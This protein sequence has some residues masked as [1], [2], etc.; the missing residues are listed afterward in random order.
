MNE[1]GL[2]PTYEQ[3]I[4]FY[5]K[6]DV[7]DVLWELSNTR[8]LRFFYHTDMDFTTRGAKAASIRLH[9]LASRQEFCDAIRAAARRFDGC[10]SPFFPFFGMQTC[11]NRRGRPDDV[12]GWDV[13]FE[14]DMSLAASFRGL[15]P[16][17]AVLEHFG[18]PYLAKFSGH[19]SLHVV[20]P[21]E[22]LGAGMGPT[23]SKKEWMAAVELAGR[24]LSRFTPVLT[25]T[26]IGLSKDMV[27]TAPYS[28]HR[29]HGLISTPLSLDAALAFDPKCATLESFRGV[30]WH[31]RHLASDGEA[32]ARLLESARRAEREPDTVLGI[33]QEVF[34]GEKW[35]RFAEK[36]LGECSA[37]DRVTAALFGGL[38][39]VNCGI[40]GT[41]QRPEIRDRVRRAMLW[42]DNPDAKT[43]KLLRLH[44]PVGF[45]T[46]EDQ[47]ARYREK[48]CASLAVWVSGGL[49][50]AVE[51]LLG[52][53]RSSEVSSP[54]GFAVR[55]LSMLP[56]PP[57][58]LLRVLEQAWQK[59]AQLDHRAQALLVLGL[60]ELGALHPP[61]LDLLRPSPASSDLEDL[62]ALLA[63]AE[64]W[65]TEER[66]DLAVAALSLCFG[67]ETVRSW[68]ADPS[69]PLAQDIV[70]NV[71][72]WD[73]GK[74]R[75]AVQRAGLVGGAKAHV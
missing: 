59:R 19:R 61:A 27:L 74:F 58:D 66:P 18:V 26:S 43:M 20:L 49:S 37:T 22:A 40:K 33:A 25:K 64:P 54:V 35:S 9:C 7:S 24:F 41:Q 13:R 32:M 16:I 42:I 12:I 11:V 31:P 69:D 51:H 28:F 17:V 67:A 14:L 46:S 10:A 71:F 44:T 30:D 29:Y 36:V 47:V 45:I 62:F 1:R 2:R 48:I 68:S 21:A 15:L 72:C 65:K 38:P 57:A 23:P 3:V 52:L 75:F 5:L 55:V 70:R 56:D 50:A 53:A 73:V 39:G 4:E 6:D 63:Q 60:A 34:K 8:P